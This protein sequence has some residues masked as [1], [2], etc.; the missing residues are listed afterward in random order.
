MGNFGDDH[1]DAPSDERGRDAEIDGAVPP[2]VLKKAE[3]IDIPLV[4]IGQAIEEDHHQ[5]EFEQVEQLP[6]F[7]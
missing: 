1:L 6:D 7:S 2:L 3:Q 5:R 4:G